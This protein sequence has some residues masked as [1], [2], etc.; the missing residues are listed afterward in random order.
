MLSKKRSGQAKEISES[1]ASVHAL[2]DYDRRHRLQLRSK[3]VFVFVPGD[4]H[5]PYTAG[6]LLL[7]APPSWLVWSI[8]P[9]L[10]H[11]GHKGLG[12]ADALAES[13]PRLRIVPQLLEE[14]DLPNFAQ[15]DAVV[16]LAVHSHAPLLSFWASLPTHIPKICVTIP[17]CKDYG[18]L[19]DTDLQ[20]SF[21]DDE[22]ASPKAKTVYVYAAG[23]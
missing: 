11:K 9:L 8:D 6:T 1:F 3:R 17:C 20:V 4:G 23:I 13:Q 15:C 16:V 2:L 12:K 7:Q 18:W 22:I 19:A 21:V 5:R 14:F 10:R